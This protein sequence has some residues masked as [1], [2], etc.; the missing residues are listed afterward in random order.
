MANGDDHDRA[1]TAFQPVDNSES[2]DTQLPFFGQLT[3]ERFSAMR[4]LREETESFLYLLLDGRV[5]M[6]VG[7]P[8]PGSE[9][10]LI[11]HRRTE[12]RFF[13]GCNGSPTTSSKE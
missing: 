11:D 7:F 12:R 3:P 2:P 1:P 8:Y 13:F 6:S 5:E 10:E 9:F 4:I